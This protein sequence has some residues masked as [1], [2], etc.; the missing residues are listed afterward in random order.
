MGDDSVEHAGLEV[1]RRKAGE[2]GGC[3]KRRFARK[4]DETTDRIRCPAEIKIAL[5]R[6][7]MFIS[8]PCC[9][10]NPAES[11]PI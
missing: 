10:I 1:E 7:F 3:G 4:D 9:P 6:S 11:L 2:S 8:L 5:K